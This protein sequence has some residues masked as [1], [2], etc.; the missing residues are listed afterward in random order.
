MSYSMPT[1]RYEDQQVAIANFAFF[2]LATPTVEDYRDTDHRMM[3]F[4]HNQNDEVSLQAQ[5]SHR[6]RLGV[7][8][9]DI[10][11]HTVPMANASGNVYWEMK[12]TWQ[13]V[14]SEFPATASWT[15]VNSTQSIT[16]ADQYIHTTHTLAT[17]ITAPDPDGY[18]TFLLIELRRLGTDTNDTYDTDKPSGTGA[19]N[20]G[21]LNLDCHYL[22]DRSG[23]ITR[24]DD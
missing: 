7:N 21:I 13:A 23:S 18:S 1:P 2:S 14:G 11:V 8:L 3:F 12:Y 19:A 20:L 24:F 9:G 10:H 5:F 4:A 15:T 6:R 16:A 22:V 17:D